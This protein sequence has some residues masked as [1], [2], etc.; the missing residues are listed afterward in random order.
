MALLRVFERP[1]RKPNVMPVIRSAF[2]RRLENVLGVT[3]IRMAKFRTPW[4][5]ACVVW[6]ILAWRPHVIGI[7]F[8]EVSNTTYPGQLDDC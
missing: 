8:F 7:L 1:R 6:F 3:G 2:R 5:E 4:R